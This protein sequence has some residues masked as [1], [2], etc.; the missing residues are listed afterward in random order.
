MADACDVSTVPFP[1]VRAR[2]VRYALCIKCRCFRL[3]EKKGAD[4]SD[5]VANL[6]ELENLAPGP[7]ARGLPLLSLVSLANQPPQMNSQVHPRALEAA[8]LLDWFIPCSSQYLHRAAG[9]TSQL[10]ELLYRTRRGETRVKCAMT[11]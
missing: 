9:P 7:L 4:P 6:Y 11:L 1:E 10:T 3:D 5:R 2:A 8:L